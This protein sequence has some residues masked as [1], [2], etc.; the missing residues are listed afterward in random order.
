MT[1]DIIKYDNH[2]KKIV[3]EFNKQ[4]DLTKKYKLE[5][6]KKFLTD[7]YKN[8]KKN[9]RIKYDNNG[10]I[11]KKKPSK[12]NMFIKEN[13]EKIKK[14]NPNIKDHKELLKKAAQLWK[15]EKEKLNK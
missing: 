12:Y 5:E 6:I 8:T 3:D 10:N 11:I 15:I 7:I 9:K 13:M 4:V 2:T 1:T 14:E